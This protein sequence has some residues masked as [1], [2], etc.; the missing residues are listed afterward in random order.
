MV[1]YICKV[2][3]LKYTEQNYSGGTPKE[4]EKHEEK[5][6]ELSISFNSSIYK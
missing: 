1:L 2:F 4:G 5:I 6:N 3:L